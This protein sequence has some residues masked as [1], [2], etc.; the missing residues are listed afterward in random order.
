M[1]C[2]MLTR[3]PSIPG[4][5]CGQTRSVFAAVDAGNVPVYPPSGG[6][7]ITAGSNMSTVAYTVLF[8]R[9]QV[10]HAVSESRTR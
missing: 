8:I 3:M 1:V 7:D 5:G 4:I 9:Q 10:N 6:F 2:I